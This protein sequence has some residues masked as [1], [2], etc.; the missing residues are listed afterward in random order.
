MFFSLNSS[1]LCTSDYL[2][3]HSTE[4]SLQNTRTSLC[5][6]HYSHSSALLSSRKN[7]NSYLLWSKCLFTQHQTQKLTH[8]SSFLGSLFTSAS[9]TTTLC[10]QG[11][12]DFGKEENLKEEEDLVGDSK[13]D[14][15]HQV[16][17]EG[18][19]NGGTITLTATETILRGEAFIRP[20]LLELAP[21]TP[22][23]PF[24]AS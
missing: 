22:I 3:L 4:K 18:N 20:H 13:H 9:S 14:D 23:V 2:L 11:S 1:F 12:V 19:G 5:S 24:E 6:C 15:A 8:G 21:Y 17:Q 7:L 16:M 10:Y